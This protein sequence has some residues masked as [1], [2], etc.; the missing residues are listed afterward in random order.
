MSHKFTV[1]DLNTMSPNQARE[2]IKSQFGI[3]DEFKIKLMDNKDIMK[4]F[5]SLSQKISEI[6]AYIIV[7]TLRDVRY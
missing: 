7:L 5:F 2:T 4:K 3:V 6:Y 1:N